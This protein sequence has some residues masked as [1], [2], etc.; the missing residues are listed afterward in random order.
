M[1]QMYHTSTHCHLLPAAADALRDLLNDSSHTHTHQCIKCIT[2][3]LTAT[4]YQQQLM[5]CVT[6]WYVAAAAVWGVWVAGLQ[7]RLL[8]PGLV[9]SLLVRLQKSNGCFCV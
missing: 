9:L 4:S 3:A 1:H 8:A 7:V 5:H 6:C 2:Q